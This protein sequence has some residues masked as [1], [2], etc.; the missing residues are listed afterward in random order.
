VEFVALPDGMSRLTFILPAVEGRM[1][2]ELLRTDAKALP[3]DERTTDQK[4]ADVVMDRF[5]GTAC[6]RTV[7]VHV[8][9]PIETMLGLTDEP[10]LLDGYGPIAADLA[11]EL[12]MEGPWRGLLLDE[13]RQA[14]AMSSAKYRPDAKL[15]EMVKARSGGTC[16]APGCTSPIQELDHH[17][18]WPHG[19]TTAT[20][21]TGY[22][23]HHHHTKHDPKY[24]V[25]LDA[26]GTLRWTT[27]TGRTYTTRPHRY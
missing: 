5:L 17:I 22:C 27:P 6:E 8:T 14:T 3:K 24:Q 23:A 13:Y 18:P 2:Y 15:R 20:G 21:M 4:R 25:D 19:T 11:R 12:A 10:G 7:Q 9:V 1:I 16:A 26:D